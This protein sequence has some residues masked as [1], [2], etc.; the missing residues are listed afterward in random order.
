MNKTLR[1]SAAAGTII[2][3]TGALTGCAQPGA[4][5][6]PVPD[7][8]TET[9]QEKPEGAQP[10]RGLIEK[11]PSALKRPVD[12]ESVPYTGRFGSDAEIQEFRIVVD[13]VWRYC[14]VNAQGGM[15]CF[16]SSDAP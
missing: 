2:L 14:L 12:I 15:A 10:R 4:Q 7:V 1:A 5:P 11:Q 3:L 16:D 8:K 6:L 9:V 13:E